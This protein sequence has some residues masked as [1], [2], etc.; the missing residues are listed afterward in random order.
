VLHLGYPGLRIWG[1][2]LAIATM[3]TVHQVPQSQNS[4]LQ[5]LGSSSIEY[6][7]FKCG[8]TFE[9]NCSIPSR[10]WLVPQWP[11][12]QIHTN[13]YKSQGL[14]PELVDIRSLPGKNPHHEGEIL[15]F[16]LQNLHIIQGRPRLPNQWLR[17]T[18][19]SL[20]TWCSWCCGFWALESQKLIILWQGSSKVPVWCLCHMPSKHHITVIL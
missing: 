3:Y 6:C 5:N 14:F 20:N 1:S 2:G 18:T 8:R 4:V 16:L 7:P 11:A 13:L 9:L 17:L 15:Q 10:W 19:K 12:H